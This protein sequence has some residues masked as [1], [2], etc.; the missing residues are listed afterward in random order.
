[1]TDAV[2]FEQSLAELDA[3]LRELEDGTTTLDAALARYERGVGLLRACYG[4]LQAAEQRIQQLAGLAA[5]GTPDLK[6]FAHT[7]AVEKKAVRKRP[8]GDGAY[9]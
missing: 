4:Q 5:D 3:I 9:N 2:P 7:A 8:D 1:M 6:P